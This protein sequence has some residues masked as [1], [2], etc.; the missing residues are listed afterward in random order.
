M[1]DISTGEK[2]FSCE[3][4]I[5]KKTHSDEK[6]HTC[7]YCKRKFRSLPS[8]LDFEPLQNVTTSFHVV[9]DG[10][11]FMIKPN[12]CEGLQT[13]TVSVCCSLSCFCSGFAES[14]VKKIGRK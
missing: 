14:I 2:H 7:Q 8:F 5:H 1:R 6:P 9:F 13:A 12:F 3:L 11:F 10:I 4:K